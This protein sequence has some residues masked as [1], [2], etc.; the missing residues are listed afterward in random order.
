[1]EHGSNITFTFNFFLPFVLKAGKSIKDTLSTWLVVRVL[2]LVLLRGVPSS[3]S[4]PP[5]VELSGIWLWSCCID[6]LSG[7]L[8]SGLWRYLLCLVLEHPLMSHRLALVQ[9]LLWWP[10]AKQ[11]KQR[12]VCE[13]SS[14]LSGIGNPLVK[15]WQT[16]AWW[17]VLLTGF[18]FCLFFIHS[19]TVKFCFQAYVLCSPKDYISFRKKKAV[20]SFQVWFRIHNG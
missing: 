12:P 9:S 16:H 18:L 19:N 3:C 20:I 2:F 1:M 17:V 13:I 4:N 8:G 7:P 6:W 11:R 5:D 14:F 10:V 15:V